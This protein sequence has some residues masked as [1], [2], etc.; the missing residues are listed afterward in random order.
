MNS[1][2]EIISSTRHGHDVRRSQRLARRRLQREVLDLCST[3]D[4]QHELRAVMARHTVEENR[5][6]EGILTGRSFSRAF[7]TAGPSYIG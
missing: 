7:H 6:L 3:R 2:T 5:E 1:F 4:G